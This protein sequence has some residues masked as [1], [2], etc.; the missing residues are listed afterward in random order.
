MEYFKYFKTD[1]LKVI[2]TL[3]AE[4]L[5]W[6]LPQLPDTYPYDF[7]PGKPLTHVSIMIQRMEHFCAESKVRE[8]EHAREWIQWLYENLNENAHLTDALVYSLLDVDI[9][10]PFLRIQ[11]N[12]WKKA[13][14]QF[15]KALLQAKPSLVLSDDRWIWLI[16]LIYGKYCKQCV[17]DIDLALKQLPEFPER[18]DHQVLFAKLFCPGEPPQ[19]LIQNLQNMEVH[20]LEGLFYF[21]KHGSFDGFEFEQIILPK[22][23]GPKW[24]LYRKNYEEPLWLEAQ[25]LE[26]VLVLYKLLQSHD[27]IYTARY[28]TN[29]CGLFWN[30]LEAFDKNL[31]FW[32]AVCAWTCSKEFGIEHL[33]VEIQSI[34]DYLEQNQDPTIF[35]RRDFNRVLELVKNGI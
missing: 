7:S 22:E 18:E 12:P 29:Y 27:S 6:L 26:R 9:I 19:L 13:S 35:E 11:F 16:A 8:I 30:D 1:P 20:D 15:L 34:F 17:T 23:F 24:S 4:P 33:V 21:F 32:S 2:E 28:I 3:G 5:N 10:K 14:R 25:V 31:S